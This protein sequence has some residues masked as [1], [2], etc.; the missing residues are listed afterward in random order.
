MGSLPMG[1]DLALAMVQEILVQ[2]RLVMEMM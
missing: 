2:E 1:L